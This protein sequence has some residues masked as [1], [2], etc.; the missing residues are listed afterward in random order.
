MPIF[1]I[2][3][4]DGRTV[5]IEAADQAAA[6]RGA[7]E[8]HAANPRL[9]QA[10]DIARS[11]VSG[12]GQ[13]VIN[14]AGMAGD[15]REFGRT[16]SEA[17]GSAVGLP[18]G[19]GTSIF[20]RVI[21]ALPLPA[22]AVLAIAP[23]SQQGR[24]AATQQFGAFHQP[25]WTAG[26]YARSVGEFAPGVLFPA[27]SV[28]QRVIGGAVGPGLGAE[29]ARQATEGTVLEPYAPIA[30]A[31]AGA[32]IGTAVTRGGATAA[33]RAAIPNAEDRIQAT[34]D[35]SRAGYQSPE[36]AA[37]QFR[38]N[39][40][41]ALANTTIRQLDRARFNDRIAPA[42]RAILDDL[43]QPVNGTAHTLEDLQTARAQ[44]ERLAGNFANPIE[45]AAAS[46][47]I[48]NLTTY[49]ERMPQSH[50]LAGNARAASEA[51]NTARQNYSAGRTAE[52]VLGKL[53][54]AE[55]QAQSAN[56]G[57]NAG[58]A[59]RQRLRPLLNNRSQARGLTDDESAAIEATVRGSPT[60]NFLRYTGNMFGGGGGIGTALMAGLGGAGTT[61]AGLGPIGAA[62]PVV[63]AASRMAGNALTRRQANNVVDQILSRAPA[64]EGIRQQGHRTLSQREIQA[65]IAQSL[66]A[67][68]LPGS[69]LRILPL[70]TNR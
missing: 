28:A 23:T 7:Q 31:F 49:I 36:I 40:V 24:E 65:L 69:P 55:N 17:A 51:W 33:Q 62:L 8:W 63:G 11:A 53:T 15:A 27:R 16:G 20:N 34:L 47:A 68:Q 32:G 18:Q 26:Q 50:L 25:Q 30:G 42:T 60:G 19:T 48:Q 45:Q 54:A 70:E 1:D 52:K 21:G 22:Q 67:S 5:T 57:M 58:N 9:S 64:I 37:V 38:P 46:R 14:T 10:E 4:P 43:R 2:A 6:L 59:M 61:F 39:I 13:G 44:L 12:L 41:D 66:F 35:A 3:V 56:S 29:G